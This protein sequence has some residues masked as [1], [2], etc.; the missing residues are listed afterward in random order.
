MGDAT[1]ARGFIEV[2]ESDL[3]IGGHLRGVIAVAGPSGAL[4]QGAFD[5]QLCAPD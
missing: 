4:V 3:R 2:R 5:A 1:S